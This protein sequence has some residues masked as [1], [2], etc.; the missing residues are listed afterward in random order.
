MM[1]VTK[2]ASEV[3][4][5]TILRVN[6][7]RTVPIARYEEDGAFDR[8]S[9]LRDLAENYGFDLPTLIDIADLLGAEEDFDGLI[10]T[11]DDGAEGFG[12]AAALLAGE[13]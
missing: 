7:A 12:F 5:A 1:S 6:A 8:Y 13:G 4:L 2:P 10:S 11:L 3:S 9:Y